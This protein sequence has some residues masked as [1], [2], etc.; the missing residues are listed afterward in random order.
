MIKK[1]NDH[2][3]KNVK[4]RVVRLHALVLLMA[5]LSAWSVPSLCSWRGGTAA[6]ETEQQKLRRLAAEKAEQ[7]RK[8]KEE[9]EK[10]EQQERQEQQ[11]RDLEEKARRERE[12]KEKAGEDEKKAFDAQVTAMS[13]QAE[14]RYSRYLD[15]AYGSLDKRW[16]ESEKTASETVSIGGGMSPEQRMKELVTDVLDKARL[17]SGEGRID[18]A[19][20]ARE[21]M[22]MFNAFKYYVELWATEKVKN[23]NQ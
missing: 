3:V 11:Q 15:E 20:R 12:A 21:K 17:M 4:A 2:D 14:D 22:M 5:L 19:M 23:W 16:Q 8:E 10:K 6:P 18:V 1:S 13:G 9:R 7:E